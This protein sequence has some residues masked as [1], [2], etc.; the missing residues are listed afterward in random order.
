MYVRILMQWLTSSYSPEGR[1]F[2]CT[3]T[4]NMPATFTLHHTLPHVT[5]T[6]V[7]YLL[8]EE[9]TRALGANLRCSHASPV[10]LQGHRHMLNTRHGRN[11]RSHKSLWKVFASTVAKNSTRNATKSHFLELEKFFQFQDGNSC[12]VPHRT[13]LTPVPFTRNICLLCFVTTF[14]AYLCRS[15]C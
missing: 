5:S 12:N 14:F 11:S 10:T 6:S 2:A 7:M 9:S 4:V 8:L 15:V 1:I 13:N 3:W